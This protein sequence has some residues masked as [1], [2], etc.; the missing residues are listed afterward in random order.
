MILF[1][2]FRFFYRLTFPKKAGRPRLRLKLTAPFL[3]CVTSD[4]TVEEIESS[5]CSRFE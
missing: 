2:I 4:V 3:I 5:I 1:A